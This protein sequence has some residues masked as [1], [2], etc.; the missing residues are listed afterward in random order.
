MKSL[1]VAQLGEVYG[2][3][4]IE[5]VPVV[6]ARAQRLD[7]ASRLA[8]SCAQALVSEIGISGPDMGV[9]VLTRFGAIAANAEHWQKYES[10]GLPAVSPLIFPATVPSAA[11]AEV[12]IALSAMGPNVT[13]CGDMQALPALWLMAEDALRA[14]D[15]R[16]A[17]VGFVDGWHASLSGFGLT[18]KEVDGASFVALSL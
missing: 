8:L 2:K 13:L 5:E 7:R 6:H 15:C 11:A 17:L 12:A 1:G 14:E 16:V 4:Y 10:G 9:F 3:A 18:R